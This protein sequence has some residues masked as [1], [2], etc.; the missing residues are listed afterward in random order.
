MP[1]T[2]DL[3]Y[4]HSVVFVNCAFS[5][6][7]LLT[8]RIFIWGL[9]TPRVDPLNITGSEVSRGQ[10]GMIAAHQSRI[11]RQLNLATVILL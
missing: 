2:S 5:F 3:H 8:K 1:P 11:H 9:A 6:S 7:R 10:G 4:L